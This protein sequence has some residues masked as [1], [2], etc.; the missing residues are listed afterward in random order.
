MYVTISLSGS[1]EDVIKRLEEQP[2]QSEQADS[3]TETLV[4]H[5]LAEH[6]RRHAGPGSVSLSA[7]I[8][9]SHQKPSEG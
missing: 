4:R 8:S 7:S 1:R 2:T 5:A 6:L 9:V 3:D